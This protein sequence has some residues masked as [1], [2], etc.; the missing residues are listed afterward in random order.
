MVTFQQESLYEIIDEVDELLQLHYTELTHH[1]HVVKLKP[2]WH[3][4]GAL[5]EMGLFVVY[6][7]RDDARLIGYSAFFV[8]QHLHYEDLTIGI[9]DVLFLHPEWRKGLTGIRLL[10][11]SELELKKLGVHKVTWHCKDNG[12]DVILKRLGY[13]HEEVVMGKII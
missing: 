9:N 13:K 2:M 7:A 10:K 11:F 1:K 3:R 5:E 6:T 4:Y 8:N 12:L